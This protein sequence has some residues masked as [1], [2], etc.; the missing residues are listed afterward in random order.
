[1]ISK[2]NYRIWIKSL[3]DVSVALFLA[4]VLSPLF[5][6]IIILRG[7]SDQHP[8]FFFQKRATINGEA[9]TIYKFCTL[10]ED[11]QGNMIYTKFGK[12]LRQSSIDEIPQLINVLR[13][14][15]SLVG[16]RPLPIEYV[17]DYSTFQRKRLEVKAGVTGLAQVH[18]RNRLAWSKRFQFDALYVDQMGVW[19]DL[20]ILM[21]TIKICLTGN[22]VVPGFNT[23]PGEEI[24]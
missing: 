1:M 5:V 23:A 19:L 21:S 22:G 10:V 16:P 14:E 2:Q 4:F 11:D 15:M 3:F 8:I 9:F 24:I 20:K 18:G 6:L 7:F 17:L 12:W 13:G